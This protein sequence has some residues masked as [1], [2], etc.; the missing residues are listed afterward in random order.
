MTLI[1]LKKKQEKIKHLTITVL[2]FFYLFVLTMLIQLPTFFNLDLGGGEDESTFILMGQSLLDGHLPY[3]ELWDVKPPL[4][5]VF[6]ALTIAFLGKSIL[7]VRIAGAICITLAAFVTYLYGKKIWNPKIGILSA[8]LLT[9][10][11]A[12][13]SNPGSIT[14]TVTAAQ[15]AIVPL[16]ASSLAIST[17]KITAKN[18]FWAGIFM[19]I[20]MMIRLNLA[21]V[22]IIVGFALLLIIFQQ[23]S[24]SLKNVLKCGLAYAAGNFLV[25]FITYLPYWISGYQKVWWNSVI[26]A[27]LSYANTNLSIL[28]A[29]V[30]Q[31]RYLWRAISHL[32]FTGI[33]ILVWFGGLGGFVL[34]L[35][36]WKSLA[37]SQKIGLTFLL[38]FI[39][40]SE[41]SILKGGKAFGHYYIQI[42]P[43]LCLAS[44]FL[45]DS[46]LS[47]WKRWFLFPVLLLI[48]SGLISLI[49]SGYQK[50]FERIG[51]GKPMTYGISIEIFDYLKQD[52][53][54]GEPIF[55]LNNHIVY[56]F[57]NSKPLT[58]S[59]TQPYN[60]V[61]PNILK[62]AAAPNATTDSELAIIFSKKPKYIVTK[63][64]VPFRGKAGLMFKNALKNDYQL[65]KNIRGIKIYHRI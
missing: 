15:I 61:N 36:E 2:I 14:S 48:F 52:N 32:P 8:T 63:Y 62:F 27:S 40:A 55:L 46:L 57:L 60:I 42:Y 20:S 9:L 34:L 38:I 11:I 30:A 1:E 31:I 65:V 26:W 56:W 12:I 33:Y 41:I 43:F 47:N 50:I 39:L 37:K 45:L 5:F 7:S 13:G 10:I 25:V 3:T 59:T 18:C 17:Q 28:G 64:S 23:V 22:G 29:L 53:Y 4:L 49:L 54:S 6:F 58:K 44:G 16:I 21:Y 51:S 19:G 35:S 24:G